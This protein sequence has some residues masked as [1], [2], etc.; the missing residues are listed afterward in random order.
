MIYVDLLIIGAALAC[1]A[2]VLIHMWIDWSAE[3]ARK[4][5]AAAYWQ[6]A[7]ESRADRALR[8][9]HHRPKADARIQRRRYAR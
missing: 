2:I 6:R 9:M 5:R 8:G 7:I 4:R 3:R 1:L